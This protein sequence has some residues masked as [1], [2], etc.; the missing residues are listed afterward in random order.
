MEIAHVKLLIILSWLMRITVIRLSSD[1][2]KAKVFTEG[3][4][5]SRL[6]ASSLHPLSYPESSSSLASGW[7]PG[8]RWPKSPRTLGRTFCW[9]LVREETKTHKGLV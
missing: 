5:V 1:V 8:N 7:T 2:G 3:L 4:I 9:Q 6:R